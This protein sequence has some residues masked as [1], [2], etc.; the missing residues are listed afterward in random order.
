[1][2]GAVSLPLLIRVILL[3]LVAFLEK[4]FSV[5][6]IS[7][8]RFHLQFSNLLF[9]L[10]LW[11]EVGL[12]SLMEL[13]GDC[14]TWKCRCCA[15]SGLLLGETTLFYCRNS[16]EFLLREIVLNLDIFQ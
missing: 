5:F 8:S 4:Y 11:P 2:S 10:C 1:M 7:S 9:C 6:V 16:S 15:L 3:L 12:N 14:S 13:S